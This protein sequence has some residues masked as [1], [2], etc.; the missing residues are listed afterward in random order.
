MNEI[1]VYK[2]YKIKNKK[3]YKRATKCEIYQNKM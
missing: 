1:I 3:K 2:L